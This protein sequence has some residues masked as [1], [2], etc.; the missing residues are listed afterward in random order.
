MVQPGHWQDVL[1]DPPEELRRQILYMAQHGDSQE[2]I[3]GRLDVSPETVARAF[4]LGFVDLQKPSEYLSFIGESEQIR[5]R[6]PETKEKFDEV[7]TTAFV[8]LLKPAGYRKKRLVWH[9]PGAEVWPVIDIQ[10]HG[11]SSDFLSL[12]SNW[13]VHVPGFVPLR[14]P[15]EQETV[16][17]SMCALA[18][19]IGEFAADG[20]DTWW[21]VGLGRLQR[22]LPR[23]GPEDSSG[24]IRGLLSEGVLPF[25]DRFTTITT[26]VDYIEQL[27]REPQV[28][29]PGSRWV[30]IQGA[31]AV[32]VLRQIRDGE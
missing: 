29:S 17:C 18:G 25:L 14:Y 1:V 19:R 3:A 11:S 24:E 28:A 9:R 8:S 27:R 32:P 30:R 26:L 12:T 16:G 13:G 31:G 10:R 15:G 21:S 5:P 6:L 23:P 22:H 20:A 4:E 2:V 7:V